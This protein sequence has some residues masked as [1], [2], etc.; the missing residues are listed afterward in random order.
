[1]KIELKE[2][3]FEGLRQIM[4]RDSS[5]M[6]M[7]LNSLFNTISLYDPESETE[8]YLRSSYNNYLD[9]VRII[10]KNK[11]KG[12]GTEV[13]NW[14]KEYSKEKGFI[15]IKVESTCTIEINKFCEK[16]GFEKTNNGIYINN[17]WHGDYILKI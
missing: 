12:M 3:D 11:H 4:V 13:L 17:V 9:I 15:G 16:F 14:L 6:V 10:F 5:N 1:M 8:L 2:S 7:V